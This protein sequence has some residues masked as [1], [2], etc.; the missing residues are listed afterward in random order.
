MTIGKV[1][2]IA[3]SPICCYC[4]S[5]VVG[6]TVKSGALLIYFFCDTVFVVWCM[7]SAASGRSFYPML[8]VGASLLSGVSI[9]KTWAIGL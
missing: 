4:F 5:R 6:R 1:N 7:A 2:R 8:K 9:R 3:R